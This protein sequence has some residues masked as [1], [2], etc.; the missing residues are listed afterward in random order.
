MKL[1]AKVFFLLEAILVQLLEYTLCSYQ[2]ASSRVSPK[3]P[4]KLN[5]G[6]GEVKIKSRKPCTQSDVR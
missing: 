2:S 1:A 3:D 4:T 5:Q 6:K